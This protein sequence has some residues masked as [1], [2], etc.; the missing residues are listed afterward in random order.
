MADDRKTKLFHDLKGM[1]E[2][3]KIDGEAK[4][5]KDFS[6]IFNNK[7]ILK[8][9][10]SRYRDGKIEEYLHGKDVLDVI[11]GHR[12]RILSDIK[13]IVSRGEGGDRFSNMLE[14]LRLCSIE[15]EKIE[16][17]ND[18]AFISEC[19]KVLKQLEAVR[20]EIISVQGKGR[21]GR[22]VYV[23]ISL[24]VLLG[25]VCLSLHVDRRVVGL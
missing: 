23:W 1:V 15:I 22:Q 7:E 13:E 14:Y 20:K 10:T 5:Y 16:V 11:E 24:A 17:S 12:E 19:N 8:I 18:S 4:G 3:S 2:S 25:A 9:S 21:G 6:D